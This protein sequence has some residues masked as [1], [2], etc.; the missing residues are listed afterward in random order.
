MQLI[1]QLKKYFFEL[2]NVAGFDKKTNDD[3]VKKVLE[4]WMTKSFTKILELLKEE[5][6]KQFTELLNNFTKNIDNELSKKEFFQ[7]FSS[8]DK[9]RGEK[10]LDI[11]YDEAG[12][13]TEIMIKKFNEK[14]TPQQKKEYAKR[15]APLFDESLKK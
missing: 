5:E 11:F 8:L 12:D 7:F 13:I 14:S 10:I 4:M 15:V 1:D 9:D 3:M 6:K 2:F